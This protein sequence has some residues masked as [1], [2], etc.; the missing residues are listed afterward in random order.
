MKNPVRLCSGL[1]PIHITAINLLNLFSTLP[2]VHDGTSHD[3]CYLAFV[4]NTTTICP[5]I[6]K[7]LSETQTY[8]LLADDVKSSTAQLTVNVCNN[9]TQKRMSQTQDGKTKVNGTP[10]LAECD[11]SPALSTGRTLEECLSDKTIALLEDLL[12]HTERVPSGALAD[13]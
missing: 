12:F 11:V 7:L 13:G 8:L 1:L 4:Q 9:K 6:D 10:P 3:L 2:T 5:L